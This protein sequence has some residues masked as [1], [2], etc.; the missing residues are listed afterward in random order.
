MTIHPITI[1]GLVAATQLTG[2]LPW[3]I[4]IVCL[5]L[6]VARTQTKAI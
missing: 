5:L 3:I 2:V 1:I 4:F 6:E